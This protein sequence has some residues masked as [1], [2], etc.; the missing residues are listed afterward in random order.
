MKGMLS[1]CLIVKN[2]EEC[3]EKCLESVK[4]HVNEIVLVDT[5]ST[6]RTV[7]LA[8]KYA[9]RIANFKWVNDFSKARNF[10]L[11]CATN[12]WIFII[13]ADQAVIEWNDKAIDSFICGSDQH[14]V[15]SVKIISCFDDN[16]YGKKVAERQTQLLNKK[17]HCFK[18][19][20]HEQV[21]A[22]DGSPFERVE[23][24]ITLSHTG[25]T[26]DEIKRK[27]KTARNI[28]LLKTALEQKG[29]DCYLWYQLGKSYVMNKNSDDACEC[30]KNAMGLVE[31][32]NL[33][34]VRD[35]VTSY[36]YSLCN[37][38]DFK[39][40]LQI[41][42]YHAF[43]SASPDFNF[44]LG[45]VYMMN[46]LFSKAAETFL[47]CTTQKNGEMEG[48]T[49]WLPLYNIG[50]IFECL[51]KRDEALAYYKKCGDYKKALERIAAFK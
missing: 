39:G 10:S 24:D 48:V 5:G 51:G 22:L 17:Y 31:N 8:G 25:Y 49:S 35:L 11:E 21:T 29:D 4:Q 41:E 20:I 14:K 46:G 23:V 36:G 37:I 34:F 38:G 3:I 28:S 16:G 2:E 1:A 47:K 45:Y 42:K 13:D 7:E 33:A 43:Y 27:D 26:N 32:F 40:A 44:L 15:G 6:D 50:V 12:D 30:F 9:D 19:S 18:G